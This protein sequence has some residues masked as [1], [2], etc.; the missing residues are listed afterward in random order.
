M[1]NFGVIGP[2]KMG[3]LFIRNF[4]N[5]GAKLVYLKASNKNRTKKKKIFLY[6]RKKIFSKKYR[7]L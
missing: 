6:K 1:A 4:L 2:G 5:I 7:S 3:E